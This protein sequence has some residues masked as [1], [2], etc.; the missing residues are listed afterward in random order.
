MR[1]GQGEL[2]IADIRTP[3]RRVVEFQHSAIS[4]E[5]V[6]TRTRFHDRIIWVVDGLRRKTDLRQFDRAL[7]DARITRVPG[8]IVYEFYDL[9]FTRLL[10]DWGGLDR[11]VVLDFGRHAG[12]N[13]GPDEN[14]CYDRNDLFVFRGTRHRGTWIFS[15]F[16]F[17]LPRDDFIRRVQDGTALPNI[18]FET[19]KPRR[20]GEAPWHY[21]AA[22]EF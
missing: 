8:T 6:A 4:R 16:G 11:P 17:F 19:T 15:V 5:E 3:D 10:R 13:Q 2:H 14:G 20:R 7:S 1:D 21:P 18:R 9:D 22:V 12:F